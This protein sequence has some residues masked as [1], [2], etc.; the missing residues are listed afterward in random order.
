MNKNAKVS[1]PENSGRGTVAR[2]GTLLGVLLCA[3]ACAVQAQDPTE[4]VGSVRQAVDDEAP[5]TVVMF[6]TNYDGRPDV[7]GKEYSYESEGYQ[8]TCTWFENRSGNVINYN[9]RG[10]ECTN[11]PLPQDNPSE[12]EADD[13]CRDMTPEWCLAKKMG[14]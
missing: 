1:A 5:V 11:T 2:A 6:D 10:M 13:E 8:R 12:P 3:P 9:G 7:F 4:S 14:Y